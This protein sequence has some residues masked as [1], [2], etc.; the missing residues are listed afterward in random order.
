MSA[1]TTADA[2]KVS[3]ADFLRAVTGRPLQ[4]AA[5]VAEREAR[6]AR[7]RLF[8]TIQR[9]EYAKAHREREVIIRGGMKR[10][11]TYEEWRQ[12][13]NGPLYRAA[14]RVNRKVAEYNRRA[15]A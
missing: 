13:L 8:E 15:A 2:G 3:G 6:G 4:S 5:E 1:L 10:G 11:E 14:D 12:R 7:M 9:V